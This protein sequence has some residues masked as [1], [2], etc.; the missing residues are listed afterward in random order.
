[1]P[2]NLE[3]EIRQRLRG[4]SLPAAPP[5]L[6]EEIEHLRS[7]PTAVPETRSS[8]RPTFIL[9]AAALT[10][11]ALAAAAL[12][13]AGSTR[14]TAPPS[15]LPATAPATPPVQTYAFTRPG[16]A[17]DPPRGWTD[18]STAISF[19]LITQQRLV[20]YLVHGMTSCAGGYGSLPPQP[21]G[22]E[23]MATKPGTATLSILEL[24]HQYPWLPNV[25]QALRI[26]GYPA[27]L[28][29]GETESEWQIQ[30]PDEG[31]YR[32]ALISPKDE[33]AA[34]IAVVA[35]ALDSLHL[36][37]WE[38]PATVVKGLIRED[39]G[40][41]FSFDY[42][43][44]WARY[45]PLDMSMMDGAVVTVASAPLLPPC[46]GD[47]CQRFTTPPG[48][49]VIEFRMGNGPRAPDWSKAPTTVGG[50]PAFGPQNWSGPQN[51]MGADESHSWSVRLTDPSVLTLYVSLRGPEL[52]A[53]RA[54]MDQ[55][56]ASIQI[57]RQQ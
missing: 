47:Q 7:V 10:T 24:N 14:P 43:A 5:T 39:P 53:L 32:L 44:G 9:A 57:T 48:A 26:A 54:A 52:P 29:T 21:S 40:Q 28:R 11:V 35:H 8:K 16:F 34:N 41:G 51:A 49:I 25:G 55:V 4:V 38:Q 3:Q 36:S 27:K 45:Y 17:F 42:P 46:A 19:P 30:S 50:Q 15:T 2:D 20:G 23:E 1:V 6:R 33:M 13:F 18:Q 37:I 12:G 56:L 22:C 31:I